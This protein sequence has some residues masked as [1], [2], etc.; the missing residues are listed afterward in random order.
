[1]ILTGTAGTGKTTIA[2][3]MCLEIGCE[4]MMINGSEEGRLID[5]FRTKV[6][7]F[8]STISMFKGGR[9]VIIID[10]ADY[11]TAASVQPALRGIMEEYSENCTFIMTCNY[12]N[13]LIPAIASRTPAIDFTIKQEERRPM[14]IAFLKR[15]QTIC[16]AEKIEYDPAALVG[17]IKK[18][19]PDYRRILGEVQRYGVSGKIDAGI[20]ADNSDLNIETLIDALRG[21]RMGDVRLWC[22]QNAQADL[23]VVYNDL[24]NLLYDQLDNNSKIN[25]ILTLAKYQYQ[26]GFAASGELNFAACMGEILVDCKFT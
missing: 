19:F 17:L 6:R 21:K 25:M 1:M 14:A 8:A 15:L 5:T 18:H 16:V 22:A 11:M 4:Y 23:V 10:E 13:R 12:V 3:A 2:I 26:H 20:L 24:Y 7:Q 9:K